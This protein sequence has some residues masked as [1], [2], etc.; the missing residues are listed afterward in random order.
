LYRSSYPLERNLP[1]I[2]PDRLHDGPRQQH[3]E[4]CVD[5]EEDDSGSI[6][7]GMQVEHEQLGEAEGDEED[8]KRDDE[9]EEIGEFLADLLHAIIID[10]ILV[11]QTNNSLLCQRM[12]LFC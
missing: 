7:P 11:R 5:D 8:D 4:D 9:Q 6:A 12:S 2:A 3:E 1:G 10:D